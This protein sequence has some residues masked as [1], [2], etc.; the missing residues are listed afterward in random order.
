M[1]LSTMGISSLNPL[2]GIIVVVLHF[3]DKRQLNHL[4][5]HQWIEDVLH[6]RTHQGIGVLENGTN[7]GKHFSPIFGSAWRKLVYKHLCRVFY[8]YLPL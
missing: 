6:D 5:H 3:C 1:I 4:R 8:T 7:I 2:L